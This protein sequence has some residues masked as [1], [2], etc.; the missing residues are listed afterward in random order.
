MLRLV[1]TKPKGPSLETDKNIG[2][3]G[4]FTS[5]LVKIARVN[6]KPGG[7]WH[8]QPH[9]TEKADAGGSWKTENENYHTT[10]TITIPL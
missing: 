9:Y 6:G 1:L 7:Y 3:N 8:P 10:F 2:E 4:I 5:K